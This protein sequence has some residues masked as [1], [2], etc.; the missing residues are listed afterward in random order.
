MK[1]ENTTAKEKAVNLKILYT[2]LFL[3]IV[4]AALITS[5]IAENSGNLLLEDTQSTSVLTLPPATKSPAYIPQTKSAVTTQPATSA[6]AVTAPVQPQTQAAVQKPPETLF[7]AAVP[8]ESYYSLPLSGA[9]TKLYSDSAPV[10][11]QTMGDWRAHNAV[12]FAGEQGDRVG[13]VAPG[14]VKSVVHDELLGW[15]V[16]IDHGNGV[17]A[18]YCGLSEEGIVNEGRVLGINDTVGYL[19]SVP[20]ESSDYSHLHFTMTINDENVNPMEVMS[21]AMP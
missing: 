14:E 17:V 13:S 3:V 12:D 11:S 10:Y 4:T 2:A 19:A 20:C 15:S 6:P 9:T 8:Y 21:K 7:A 16:Y 18:G 1:N 5:Y